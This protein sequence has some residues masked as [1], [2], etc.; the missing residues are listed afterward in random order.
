VQNDFENFV[1]F[2]MIIEMEGFMISIAIDGGTACGKGTI[3]KAL[4]DKLGYKV[5]DTGA[6]FRGFACAFVEDGLEEMNDEIIDKFVKG[7]KIEVK[8]DKELQRV[9]VNGKDQTANLRT[10]KTSQMASKIS[11]FPKV[12]TFMNEVAREFAKNNNCIVEGRDITTV[13]LPNATV[14]FFFTA[15]PVVRAKRR[16]NQLI[17]SGKEA[18]F[19]DVYKDLLERDE[20]DSKRAVAPLKP[21]EGAIIMDNSDMTE[22]ESI[23]FCYNKILEKI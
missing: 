10:E 12:R 19:E 3:A 23:E 17:A 15:D 16:V 11:V 20:R 8:F 4:A 5:L 2:D 18:N 21:A 7:L 6:I 22:Q 14:K 9:F 1:F 13:V